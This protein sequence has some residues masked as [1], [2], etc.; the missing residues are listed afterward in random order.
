MVFS[1]VLSSVNVNLEQLL[2]DYDDNLCVSANGDGVERAA[3]FL[4]YGMLRLLLII[5]RAR[6]LRSRIRRDLR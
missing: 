3:S 1:S 4:I 2:Q 6:T 5:S